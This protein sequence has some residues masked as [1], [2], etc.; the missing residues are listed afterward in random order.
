MCQVLKGEFCLWCMMILCGLSRRLWQCDDTESLYSFSQ[1]FPFAL[2]SF[3]S[4]S[5]SSF[6]RFP[7]L[8]WSPVRI[9]PFA[10]DTHCEICPPLFLQSHTRLDLLYV[11]ASSLSQRTDPSRESH[12]KRNR[13]PVGSGDV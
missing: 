7:F 9:S 1:G 3:C 13:S 6:S 8:S 12:E 11:D 5:V 4:M 10:C 2:N